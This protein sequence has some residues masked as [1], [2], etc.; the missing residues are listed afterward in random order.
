MGGLALLALEPIDLVAQPLDL[1]L[2]DAQRRA[3]LFNQIQQADDALACRLIRDPREVE[4]AEERLRGLY[5]TRPYNDI[6]A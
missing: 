6:S 5:F 2:G 4:R 3:Q 1:F